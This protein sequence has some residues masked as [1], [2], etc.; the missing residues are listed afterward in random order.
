MRIDIPEYNT[1]VDFADSTS[2]AEVQ[3][4]LYSNFPPLKEIANTDGTWKIDI[5][6][7][8]HPP[9]FHPYQQPKT[10]PSF[11]EQVKTK[12]RTVGEHLGILSPEPTPG[13]VD[14]GTFENLPDA[15]KENILSGA[16]RAGQTQATINDPSIRDIEN[17]RAN[18]Q[19][20][21]GGGIERVHPIT[22][23][24]RKDIWRPTPQEDNPVKSLMTNVSTPAKAA[25]SGFVSG[26]SAGYIPKAPMEGWEKPGIGTK[27]V[28]SVG[29]LSGMAIPIIGGARILRTIGVL[30]EAAGIA[31]MTG[32]GITI[33]SAWGLIKHPEENEDR[34]T[35]AI[36]DAA[37]FGTF[38]GAGG[39]IIKGLSTVSPTLQG[40][41]SKVE[42]ISKK[43]QTNTP[44]MPD[45]ALTDAELKAI[46]AAETIKSVS[47]GAG[48]G[49]SEHAE[50]WRDRLINIL[51]GGASFG[52]VHALGTNTT[53]AY[54][55]IQDELL[56]RNPP[57][58]SGVTRNE[59]AKYGTQPPTSDIVNEALNS[60]K[61]AEESAQTFEAH[62]PT[63]RQSQFERGI[64]SAEA[65]RNAP[66]PRGSAEEIAK[67]F[68][69]QGNIPPSDASLS[70]NAERLRQQYA[71]EQDESEA[72]TLSYEREHPHYALKSRM[73][74]D[75][76]GQLKPIAKEIGNNLYET[77]DG[78]WYNAEG[79]E[80]T[81]T[82]QHGEWINREMGK[83][84]YPPNEIQTTT[85]KD[86]I[87][88][89]SDK[90]AKQKEVIPN[91][92]NTTRQGS[93]EQVGV[94]QNGAE[95]GQEVIPA[96]IPKEVASNAV[97]EGQQPESN[98]QQ[99]QAGKAGR[100]VAETGGS[101]R[102]EQSGEVQQIN[103]TPY[104]K[105]V[106][107]NGELKAEDAN[108]QNAPEGQREGL[109][110][111]SNATVPGPSEGAAPEA[112]SIDKSSVGLPSP[113]TAS[114]ERPVTEKNMQRM[115]ELGFQLAE[116]R[117]LLENKPSTP[118]EVGGDLSV[119]RS[120]SSLRV[121]PAQIE[122]IIKEVQ[123]IA[124]PGTQV[125][126]KD[127]ITIDPEELRTALEAWGEGN[128]DA[129]INIR[130][131]HRAV[132][133]NGGQF[134]SLIELSL[135]N[136]DP[137]TTPYH[138]AFHSVQ[139][140]LLSD[141]E[142]AIIEKAYPEKDGI[143]SKERQ[144]EAFAEY[145][146]N[147]GGKRVLIP[148]RIRSI[149]S[150]IAD[151]LKRMKE[152]L[153]G[154]RISGAQD[155]FEKAYSGEYRERAK[156]RQLEGHASISIS[157]D[158]DNEDSWLRNPIE[159]LKQWREGRKPDPELARL[160][161]QYLSD[162]GDISKKDKAS[163]ILTGK[164]T[165]KNLFKADDAI[166]AKDITDAKLAKLIME[167]QRYKDVQWKQ[168]E[169]RRK[170]WDKETEG[171]RY[172]FMVAVD[173][174]GQLGGEIGRLAKEY[175]TRLDKVFNDEKAAGLDINYLKD[176]FPRDWE[177]PKGVMEWLNNKLTSMGSDKYTKER[178]YELMTDA[179]KEGF[180]LKDS[181][182]ETSIL[183]REFSA[184]RAITAENFMKN[185]SEN[186]L[187]IIEK[188]A[189]KLNKSGWDRVTVNGKNWLIE[190]EIS[191]IIKK[192][193]LSDSL[194]NRE[195][196]FGKVFRGF[197]SVK[198][199]LIPIKLGL[200]GF[201]LIHIATMTAPQRRAVIW[202]HLLK[203]GKSYDGM[204]KDLISSSL[205]IDQG[206][207]KGSDLIKA[208]ETP[209]AKLTEYDKQAVQY[210]QE[211]GFSPKMS[212]VWR[213]NATEAFG[214]AVREGKY[215]I[216]GIRGAQS[217]IEA[218]QKPLFE[219]YIPAIKTSAYIH[220]VEM[221][222]KRMP[223][224][225]DNATAR[226]MEL[227]RIAKSIDN[228]FGELNYSTLFWNKYLKEV[229]IA[230]SLSMG[231]NL[232][233]LREYG[234]A[235][236]DTAKAIRNLIAGRG[237]RE[238]I[239]RRMLFTLDYT[240][241]SAIIGGLITAGFLSVKNN[242]TWDEIAKSLNWKDFLYPRTGDVNLDGSQERMNTPFYTKE[243]PAITEHYQKEGAIGGTMRYFRNKA[244][245]MLSSLANV[246]NNKDFYGQEIYSDNDNFVRKTVDI[247]K[248]L[249]GEAGPISLSSYKA[250]AKTDSVIKV[251]SFVGFSKAPAYITKTPMQ[252]EIGNL[253]EKR[254][255]GGVNP[256][257][258]QKKS[259]I[260]K[261]I[262][263]LY[264]QG[265]EKE[266]NAKLDEAIEKGYIRERGVRAFI[267]SLDIPTDI[268]LFKRLPESDQ[269]ALV[270]K[271]N[272][273]DLKK[274]LWYAKQEI[275]DNIIGL[276][277]HGKKLVGLYQSGLIK[278]PE[279]KLGRN[280]NATGK[281]M[282]A[283]VDEE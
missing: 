242:M 184:N 239:T 256:K 228:R 145:A 77:D 81:R 245:P 50:D 21:P 134:S 41:I 282:S 43:A 142:R 103:N 169:N 60:R 132:P 170:W 252:N 55:G 74:I 33:G 106:M 25:V 207:G 29:E 196:I 32:N 52:L 108:A 150:R 163:I 259:D 214:R 200:S 178:Q 66:P 263:S 229:G 189:K 44:I 101:N 56:R 51:S 258:E 240:I 14:Y 280:V 208:W 151:F 159:A 104:K 57:L 71:Q 130:G 179:L 42:N 91:G 164:D 99:Y 272:Y 96:T 206:F 211:G 269:R 69:E 250:A 209:D 36:K 161:Q 75:V 156:G 90:I 181:N 249:A 124:A 139:E 83:L 15:E 79:T 205:F 283:E 88:I 222:L 168:A 235:T 226:S 122:G 76:N 248:Y 257:E 1:F 166:T 141:N 119:S 6:A 93:P 195:D 224:L 87:R 188:D 80:V 262:K 4:A 274:Y 254:F 149:F 133:F 255:G 98:Q 275:R 154:K 218:M 270:E 160:R 267:T 46:Y 192:G 107:P 165:I 215:A 110:D 147:K 281:S 116:G 143:S 31:A 158:K 8:P 53:K 40:A 261:E 243:F 86:A 204:I 30:S 78:K 264:Y 73:A 152:Y 121:P 2:P 24:E 126:V 244:N 237:S 129:E 136:M 84:G 220:E 38:E 157:I 62:A 186:S 7:L 47:L 174:G 114:I 276:N 59:I 225:M 144:A 61:S 17:Q 140:L 251:T 111:L 112:A 13:L 213:I 85:P 34:I 131:T 16:L 72:R 167:R 278:E 191:P 118:P 120:R 279:W 9:A 64:E 146:T 89:I 45:E 236:S 35:N 105:E 216:A 100:Q 190:K 268:M 202:E 125:E 37:V 10:E 176:Y 82:Y 49:A 194:W 26:A 212:G 223:E 193:L 238:D 197:A 48:A 63:L 12:A 153:T 109:L 277:S 185:L 135:A 11:L 177:N 175:R 65:L 172:A 94:G 95:K 155:I 241:Q 187:A 19:F 68:I 273:S 138:E 20:A 265:K 210:M 247:A 54:Q 199:T 182:P 117:N 28:G 3:N 137:K 234:G 5:D 123:R 217:L 23:A 97:K 266:A 171:S 201:H 92:E 219:K 232:G 198:N 113:E 253:Y 58:P 221:L 115:K 27:I 233:F 70:T 203:G 227:R 183:K 102:T 231:W 246:W 128:M 67:T 39:A 173:R 180:R 22:E 162:V 127:K 260:K 18:I 271:M 230:S 148:E